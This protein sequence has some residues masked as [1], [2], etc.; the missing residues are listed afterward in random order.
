[1]KIKSLTT[2]PLI[3]LLLLFSCKKNNSNIDEGDYTGTFTV[4]YDSETK[5][6]STKLELKDGKYHCTSDSGKIPAGGSGT[7]SID[8]GI[9][10]FID[11][12]FWTAD[13]DWNLI[14]NGE[15]KYSFNGKKLKIWAKKNNV[16]HYEYNLEKN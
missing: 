14:L 13:F 1:M 16:G 4:K 15:Y 6:G 11:K 10:T 9:I 7:Y 8:K 12:N 5:T 2:L 3:F